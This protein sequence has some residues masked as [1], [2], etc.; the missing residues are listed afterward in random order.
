MFPEDS[1]LT[2]VG[3]LFP[4]LPLIAQLNQLKTFQNEKFYSNR[5]VFKSNQFPEDSSVLVGLV[6]Y[7][8][9][10]SLFR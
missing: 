7:G 5:L 4:P 6:P 10:V 9:E 1:Y 8:T 2:G 3:S